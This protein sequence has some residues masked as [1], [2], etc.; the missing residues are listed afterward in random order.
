MKHAGEQALEALEPLLAEIRRV[1]GLQEKKRGV[2]YRKSSGFL[3]FHEDPAG[4]FAD[5]KIDGDYQRF[6]ATTARERDALVRRIK[7]ALR[8]T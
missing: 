8:R 7:T 6:P 3:H 4:L 1:D 2:F 5:L